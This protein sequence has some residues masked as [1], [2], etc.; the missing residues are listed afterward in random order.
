MAVFKHK[1]RHVRVWREDGRWG[2][3]VDGVIL[4]GW[5]MTEAQAAGAGL[6]QVEVFGKPLRLTR[7]GCPVSVG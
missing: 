4:T 3:V 5:Y 7:R 2:V 6:L 1:R